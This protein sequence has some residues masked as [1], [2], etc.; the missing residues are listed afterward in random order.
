MSKDA[1]I[2]SWVEDVYENLH[3]ARMDIEHK[4]SQGG[5]EGCELTEDELQHC[6]EAMQKIEK[7]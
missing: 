2:H 3:S 4:F 5:H 1:T 7:Q 6:F